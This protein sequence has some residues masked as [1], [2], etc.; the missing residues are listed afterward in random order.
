MRAG[1]IDLRVTVGRG[2][3]CRFSY[4]TDGESFIPL[5]ETFRA[6]GS[7]WVGAKVGVFASGDPG[8]FADYDWFRVTGNL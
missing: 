2:A 4:S 3:V 5:G 1:P 7:R 8:A 6:R